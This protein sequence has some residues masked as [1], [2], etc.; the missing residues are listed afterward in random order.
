MSLRSRQEVVD[1]LRN[2][3]PAAGRLYRRKL[4]DELCS[5]AGYDRKYAIKVL[6]G[7]RPGPR[8]RRRGGS[9]PRYTAA[10]RQ[11]LATIWKLGDYPCGKRLVAMLPLWLWA[12]ERHYGALTPD[13]R[14][15]LHQIS[16][17]TIDRLL[18]PLRW[19]LI[20]HRGGTKPGR[21]LRT[22]IPVRC[23]SWDVDRPGYLEADT[24][25]HGGESTA[26]DF[27]RSITYTDIYSGWTEQAAIWNKSAAAVLAQTR[28]IER[29]LPFPLLGFDADNGGEFLNHGLWRFFRQRP[30]PVQFTRSRAYHKNDNAHVEQKNWTKVRQLLGYARYDDP[31]LVPVVQTLYRGDWR[32]LQNFFQPLMKLRSK[33]RHGSRVKKTYDPAQTPAQRLLAWPGLDAKTRQ[34]LQQAQATLDP[35]ALSAS[36]NRQLQLIRRYLR[37][38]RRHAA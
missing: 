1:R 22:A 30:D 27:M 8:G 10:E 19:K 38:G 13:Q 35:I 37:E 32:W 28:Q 36:V 18:A 11:V 21:L 31:E 9:Q 24:V 3:Y 16:A 5:V 17:P 20:P 7:Q 33:Q 2:K 15:K 4:I 14:E 26:G 25:D 23:E 12:Y 34:W 29:E 6:N